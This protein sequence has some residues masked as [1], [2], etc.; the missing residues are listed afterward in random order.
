MRRF[1]FFIVALLVI[2]RAFS[3]VEL[4]VTNETA[5][6]LALNFT[7]EHY[8][9]V[10]T[11]TIS[12]KINAY[13]FVFIRRFQM[14]DS[15]NLAGVNIEEHEGEVYHVPNYNVYPANEFPHAG[16]KNSS[17]RKVVFPLSMNAVGQEAFAFSLLQGKLVIPSGV[18]KVGHSAFG[19]CAGLTSVH[20][21]EGLL[22]IGNTAFAECVNLVDSLH[23]P[24]SLQSIGDGAFSMCTKLPGFSG[25]PPSLK[26]IGTYAFR[27]CTAITGH[28]VFPSTVVSAGGYIFST[29]GVSSATIDRDTVPHGIFLNCPN[30][31]SVTLLNTKNILFEAFAVCK[32]LKKIMLPATVTEIGFEGFAM[33]QLVDTIYSYNPVPPVLG[34]AALMGIS[35]STCKIMVPAASIDAYKA[36]LQW[37]EFGVAI[38]NNDNR[39]PQLL[40]QYPGNRNSTSLNPSLQFLWDEKVLLTDQFSV[41]FVKKSNREMVY[42]FGSGNRVATDSTMTYMEPMRFSSLEPGAEYEVKLTAGSISDLHGNLFPTTDQ[43]YPFTTGTANPLLVLDFNSGQYQFQNTQ[44]LGLTKSAVPCMSDLIAQKTYYTHRFFSRDLFE[45]SNIPFRIYKSVDECLYETPQNYS[46]ARYVSLDNTSVVLNKANEYSLYPGSHSK[47]VV[48]LTAFPAGAVI[49]DVVVRVSATSFEGSDNKLHLKAWYNN[50]IVSEF[51][52]AGTEDAGYFDYETDS[53]GTKYYFR[54]LHFPVV[55]GV[56]IDSVALFRNGFNVVKMMKMQVNYKVTSAPVVNL[57]PDRN[58]CVMDEEYL[59]AGFFPNASYL[60]STGAKTQTIRVQTTNTYWVEVK[61]SLGASRDTIFIHSYPMPLKAFRDST[62]FKCAGESVTL[63][64]LSNPAFTY[65]WN[66]GATTQSITVTEEGLYTCVVSNGVCSTIDSVGV[67][68]RNSNLGFM[69]TPCCSAGYD[70]IQGELYRKNENNRFELHE[71]KIMYGD[72]AF[73][74]AL[75]AGDYIFK[76]HFVK[77]SNGTEN[78]WLDTYH[79]GSTI[80][81]AATVLTVDCLTD[82]MITIVLATRPTGFEFNGNATISGN[83]SVRPASTP[84][85]MK[86]AVRNAVECEAKVMLYT[87]AGQLIATSCPDN[88]GNYSFTNLPV[89]NYKL[90]VECTGYGLQEEI[91]LQLSSE[92]PEAVVNLIVDEISG[93]I[94]LATQT[95]TNA[96]VVYNG[97]SLQLFPN[98]ACDVAKLTITSLYAGRASVQL[99]DITGKKVWSSDMNILEGVNELQIINDGWKG[100]YLLQFNS[101]YLTSTT[102][103]IFE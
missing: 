81:S 21:P 65:S 98:P 48:D 99:T 59:D 14:L 12:G 70:D 5:G 57:G 76:A 23:F 62:I 20:F 67:V 68:N 89:G 54:E 93:T 74:S 29:T 32:K 83:I 9:T 101:A 100:M 15:L 77:Y 86:R 44:Y 33:C 64:A 87:A 28:V 60:W 102:V 71:S 55:N 25:F 40:F 6:I 1:Y 47:A 30:L 91:Q 82:T 31:E 45:E 94:F 56:Q 63:S 4:S 10:T 92:Q 2:T 35:R 49:T 24:Q 8:A 90:A 43:Y 34:D 17:V 53:Y 103:I 69:L 96:L 97:I 84:N 7:D 42:A 22:S 72:M 80:W 39:A 13:D 88:Q 19:S 46:P 75:P 51:Q 26:R 61:N 52:L 41:Q 38:Q 16:L 18:A 3:Q 79:N 85:G 36:A 37:G 95:G 27:E 50:S 73:F 58:I 78:P 11:L 66:T